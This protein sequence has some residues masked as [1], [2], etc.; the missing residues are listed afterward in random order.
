MARVITFSRN[1]PKYH[2][3]A[4]QPT[5]FVEKFY[6][7]LYSRNNLMDYPE[8][9]EIDETVLGMKKHTIRIG[10]RWKEGDLFSPRVWSEKPYNS[11]MIRLASDTKIVKIYDFEMRYLPDEKE[12]LILL[13]GNIISPDMI[14][15]IAINDGLTFTDLLDW[16]CY[17]SSFKGQIICWNDPQYK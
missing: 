6:N 1:F 10:N 3:K 2:P 15:D 9:L 17:P 16:F 11:K 12:S 13:D 7:S 14:R 8:G 4:G 5:K